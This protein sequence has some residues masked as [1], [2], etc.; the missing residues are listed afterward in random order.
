M[1][2]YRSYFIVSNIITLACLG[3]IHVHGLKIFSALLVLKVSTLGIIVLFIDLYKKKEFYYYR[4]LGL[5]KLKLW[6]FTLGLDL[7]LFILLIAMI[8]WLQ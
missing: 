5:S 7:G 1:T 3:L 6:G 8:T 2:F 4:N